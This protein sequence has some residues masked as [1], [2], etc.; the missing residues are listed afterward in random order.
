MIL[1]T[2]VADLDIPPNSTIWPASATALTTGSSLLIFG[3]LGDIYGGYYVFIGGL[4]WCFLWSLIA[5]F[6]KNELMLDFCRALQ[7]FGPAA[8]L[9]TGVLL[10]G[11]AYRPGPRKNIVFSVYGAC[12]PVGYFFGI[13]L[14]GVAGQFLS[15][16]WY[17]WIGAILTFVTCATSCL[18]LRSEQRRHE[19]STVKMDWLGAVLF[20]PGLILVVFSVTDSAHAPHGWKT[21]Y[22]YVPLVIGA[23]VVMAAVYVEGWVADQPLLPLD[24]FRVPGMAGLFVA[25]FFSYGVFGIWLLYAT[26]YTQNVE[27]ASPLQVVAWFVPFGVGG[28]FFSFVGG[29]FLHRISGRILLAISGIGW[30]MANLLF[31]IAPVGANYWAYTFPAMICGTLG[32]DVTYNIISIFVTT[33]LP[34]KQQGLAGAILNSLLFLGISLF[35]GLADLVASKYTVN[36]IRE[37]YK[38]VFWFSLACAVLA[39]VILL[40]F[41]KIEKA[42]SDMTADERLELFISTS[43]S[44]FPYRKDRRHFRK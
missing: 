6:S 20:F 5:G 25:A 2:L 28:L 1:P 22:I 16:R 42:R 18:A 12:A 15:W 31:A 38:P 40:A 32:I 27:G 23:F 33:S 11:S 30:I 17:F 10:L 21:P 4:A 14:G 19:I 9:S 24:L 39:L 7:G 13:V 26:I 41:V 36:G 37:G 43:P 34:E 3:R 35:L 8:F 44:K 29:L